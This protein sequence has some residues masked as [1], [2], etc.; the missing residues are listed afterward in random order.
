MQNIFWQT[1]NGMLDAIIKIFVVAFIAGLLIRKS[2]FKDEYVKGLSELVVIVLLPA[3]IFDNIT[4]SFN[5]NTQPMWWMLPLIGFVTPI[6][7]LV[8]IIPLYSK[9]LKSNLQKIPLATFQNAGYIVLPIGKIL[10]PNQFEQFALI[11]FLYIMGLNPSLWSIGKVLITHN[12]ED[13]KIKAS[14][15]ITPPIIA[16]IISLTLVFTKFNAHIPGFISEPAKMLGSATVPVATFVLGATLGAVSMKKLPKM[17]DIFKILS[18]KYLLIPATVI[19]ILLQTTLP[20]TNPLLADFFVIEASAAPAA[21]LILMVRK[22]GGDIQQTG[23]L[24]FVFYILAILFMPLNM[25]IW[26]I[27]LTMF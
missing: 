15:F 5:P 26:K 18:V 27:L 8:Y 16:N 2:I 25:A 19:F 20:K 4:T 11:D 7:F 13:K 24:M 23:S 12:K 1:F 14:A 3:M 21:N 6:V 10:Y 9:N 22:Y 17:S